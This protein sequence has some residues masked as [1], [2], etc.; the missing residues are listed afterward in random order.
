MTEELI[1][2]WGEFYGDMEEASHA[3]AIDATTIKSGCTFINLNNPI[4][5]S[6]V[7]SATDLFLC[8]FCCKPIDEGIKYVYIE[9]YDKRRDTYC[10][11]CYGDMLKEITQAMSK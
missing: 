8:N 2:P 4:K 1:E 6:G 3:D 7:V 10:D 11:V 5:G 9:W